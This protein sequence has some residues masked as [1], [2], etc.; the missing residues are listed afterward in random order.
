MESITPPANIE[1]LAEPLAHT[2]A[3]AEQGSGQTCI[4]PV[5]AIQDAKQ[6]DVLGV[7]IGDNPAPI[8][9]APHLWAANTAVNQA[10]Y[11]F[12]A[13]LAETPQLPA[14]E[15]PAEALQKDTQA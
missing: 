12:T 15:Q 6:G 10:A 8:G 14:F 7:P 11:N 1:D 4:G 2:I 13:A 9:G 3:S 5:A